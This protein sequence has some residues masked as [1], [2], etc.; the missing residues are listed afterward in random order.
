MLD[1]ESALQWMLVIAFGMAIGGYAIKEF[2]VSGFYELLSHPTVRKFAEAA[3][4]I[5]NLN[6]GGGG[7]VVG[8]LLGKLGI[9]FGGFGGGGESNVPARRPNGYEQVELEDGRV[10]YVPR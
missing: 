10:A 1:L 9:N 2:F 4:K 6:G 8:W 7:G 3:G 5:P